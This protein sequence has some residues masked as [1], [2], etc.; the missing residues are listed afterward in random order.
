M[1]HSLSAVTLD[2]I[3]HR[4][5]KYFCCAFQGVTSEVADRIYN[6]YMGNAAN[7]AQVRDGFL[8]AVADAGF[9]FSAIEVARYHRGESI[10]R[11]AEFH[12][13]VCLWTL[14]VFSF[15]QNSL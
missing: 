7:R 6:E 12:I 2:N 11:N 8:D 15:Y 5:K 14:V 10:R 1:T 4:Y 13:E 3:H 9:V